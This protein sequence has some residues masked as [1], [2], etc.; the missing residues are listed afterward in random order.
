[1]LRIWEH[2]LK[3]KTRLVSRV[4]NLRSRPN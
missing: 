1:V 2:E 3:N 4:W